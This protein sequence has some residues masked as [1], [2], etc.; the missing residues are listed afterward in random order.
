MPSTRTNCGRQFGCRCDGRVEPLCVHLICLD[1]PCPSYESLNHFLS[2]LLL[3]ILT[4]VN[5][6]E[7]MLK[8]DIS[9]FSVSKA[10]VSHSKKETVR[11]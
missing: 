10:K 7:P 1:N 11:K 8:I 4:N 3:I 9:T 5:S 6:V 2:K